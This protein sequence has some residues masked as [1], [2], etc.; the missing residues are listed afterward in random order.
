VPQR[1]GGIKK[2]LGQMCEAE[3]LLDE[4]IQP[5]FH[6]QRPDIVNGLRRFLSLRSDSLKRGLRDQVL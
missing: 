1:A 4:F 3:C 2:S 5:F 6:D